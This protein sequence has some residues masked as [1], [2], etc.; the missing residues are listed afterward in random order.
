VSAIPEADVRLSARLPFVAHGAVDLPDVRVDSYSLIV[1]EKRKFVGD[2]VNKSAF[3]DR[4]DDLRQAS[5]RKGKDPFRKIPTAD[6]G[7]SDWDKLLAKGN[8][9]AHTIISAAIADFSDTLF[10]VIQKYREAN[11][12]WRKMRGI[13]VGGGFS[14]GPVG[15]LVVSRVQKLLH[16]HS[17][18]CK[19]K[20]IDRDPDIAGIIG[21]AY[22]APA[23]IFAGFDGLLGVTSVA[24]TFAA[25]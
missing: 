12:G 23:W 20:P 19:I 2:R 25:G 8:S 14:E 3:V 9:A 21:A 24:P 11:G 5:A 13:A 16:D 6:L 18:D 4:L 17:V 15:R 10:D 7:R 1:Q 22:L